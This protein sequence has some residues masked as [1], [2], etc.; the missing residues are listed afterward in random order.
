MKLT[1]KTNKKLNKRQKIV[2]G[3]L[4][5]SFATGALVF[6]QLPDQ[7]AIHWTAI[8][9]ADGYVS[10]FWGAF[11]LPLLSLSMY[12]LFYTAR[13]L[14]RRRE[15]VARA[16]KDFEN[17]EIAVQA[18]FLYTFYLILWW[19]LVYPF[20]IMRYL[21]PAIGIV[22]YTFANII[23]QAKPNWT[24]SIRT[25]WTLK[26]KLAWQKTHQLARWLL[27]AC[28][29]LTLYAVILPSHAFWFILL[30]VVLTAVTCVIY[31]Y[32]VYKFHK[33]K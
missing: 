5:A 1:K 13:K 17:F 30:P 6:S 26:S 9:F 10:R 20:E 14:D 11:L 7:V 27:Y 33:G 12:L 2:L 22:F 28:S 18:V 15:N 8:G 32:A 31:S 25:L 23:A 29:F 24:I 4:L 16:S 21:A 3:L 19:N